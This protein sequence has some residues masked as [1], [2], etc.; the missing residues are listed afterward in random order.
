MLSIPS[1]VLQ[2]VLAVIFLMWIYR[3]YLDLKLFTKASLNFSAGWAVGWWFIPIANFVQ[4]YRIM[5]E[6]WRRSD[7]CHGDRW[8]TSGAPTLLVGWWLALLIHSGLYR[9]AAHLSLRAET[10][11]ELARANAFDVYS[12]MLDLVSV[13]LAIGVVLI[14]KRTQRWRRAGLTFAGAPAQS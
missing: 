4:P 7:P 14:I 8:Q 3:A 10:S 12:G 13:P 5:S 2:R 6:L 1:S 11:A 9:F